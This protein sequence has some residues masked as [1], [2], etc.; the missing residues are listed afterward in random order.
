MPKALL[1]IIGITCL[2]ASFAA[3]AQSEGVEVMNRDSTEQLWRF[4][5][6]LDDKEIGFH[7]FRV[8]QDGGTTRVDIEA[9]FEVRVLRIPVYRY[10]HNNSEVW[11]DDCLAGLR[12]TTNVNGERSTVRG[13][14]GI[15]GFELAQPEQARLLD[16]DCVRSFAY[17][18]HSLLEKSRLL[19][20][21]TGELQAVELRPAGSDQIELDGIPVTAD[22]YVLDT[23]AG[24]IVLWYRSD[25]NQWLSLQAPAKGG[26]VLRY[27]PLEVPDLPTADS[28][29]ALET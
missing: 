25:S 27:E 24:E 16:E 4:R 15:D 28:R 14:A 18:N 26:R 20:A 21:Q 3:G 12:A 19:N 13:E 1:K 8:V 7:E 9:D 6:L 5:V 10:S 22:R 23:G 2:L 11:Q 29:I 17:W